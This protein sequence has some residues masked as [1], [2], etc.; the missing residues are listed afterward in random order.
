MRKFLLF[1]L[2]VLSAKLTY[3]QSSVYTLFQGG[4][5]LGFSNEG[6]KG[7]FNGYHL[8]F[9][10]GK[11]FNESA[12]LGL[13]IGN[14]K[15]QGDYQTNDPHQD[16]QKVYKYEFNTFPIFIDGRLPIGYFNEA[17][18]IGLLANAGYAPG[19]GP[20]YDKGAL[21]KA[22]FFYLHD[23]MSKTKFTA[24]LVYGYQQLTKNAFRK[25][26]QHQSFHLTVGLMLK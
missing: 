9:I 16:D 6:Y 5:N 4:A 21:F 14:E 12:F 18:R 19:I 13:G 1:L 10:F 17:S 8:H 23:G 15:F 25:D 26:F 22:G 11:N 20:A 2:I 3:A 7:A 24:S